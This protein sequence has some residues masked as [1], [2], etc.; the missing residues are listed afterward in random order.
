M[1][2]IRNWF[3]CSDRPTKVSLSTSNGFRPRVESLDERVVPTVSTAITNA[4]TFTLA[5]NISNVLVAIDAAGNQTPTSFTNVRTAQA[6]R[7]GN[8]GL[9]AD[10]VFQDGS[11]THF[12]NSFGGVTAFSA[13]QAKAQFGGLILDAGT[14]YDSLGNIRL[15][16]LV[17]NNNNLDTN[18]H[19]F[20]NALGSVKELNQAIGGGLVDTGLGNN[21]RWVSTYEAVDGGTGIAVG[22]VTPA[23][24]GMLF[25]AL[26]VRKGDTATGVTT[27][28]N[29]AAFSGGAVVEYSQ[30]MSLPTPVSIFNPAPGPRA[31]LI[32]VTFE[33][34]PTTF[35]GMWNPTNDGGYALQ[36]SVGAT[37][38]PGA[39]APNVIGF[40][41]VNG[42]IKTGISYPGG[43]TM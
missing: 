26:L 41:G 19:T 6:F 24:G 38:S 23:G 34:N 42:D 33:G 22:Q 17:S 32:D 27:L 10:I 31:A 30:T 13:A 2:W 29:G 8:G 28:Y 5:V 43:V 36:Y 11:W 18:G 9:G 40:I 25:D 12:D 15:D 3:K 1:Q 16:I 4:G 35:N 21:V 37:S 14:A 20:A 7:D 39:P